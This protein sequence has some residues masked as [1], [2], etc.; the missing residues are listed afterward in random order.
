MVS[1]RHAMKNN[2]VKSIYLSFLMV[3][4]FMNAC[5]AKEPTAIV[6]DDETGKPIE[7]AVA[8]A[9]WRGPT[10]DCTL[11]QGLEGGCWGANRIIETVS[12]KEGKL[13]IWGFWNW[14]L[15]K[16][17]YPQL[18][19]YKFGY[20]C[21]DQ[22]RIFEPNMKWTKRNDFD[23]KHRIVRMKKWPVGFS[24]NE[25]ARFI[26][27]CTNGDEPKT[28]EHLL[29]KAY[30]SEDTYIIQ[31]NKKES[32]LRKQ[33]MV[34]G[35]EMGQINQLVKNQDRAHLFINYPR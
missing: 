15:G 10:S 6:I 21:W 24:F 22:K 33:P 27:N 17:R 19:V 28:K 14:H 5:Q 13:N 3:M 25:H 26:S 30:E 12:D 34:S 31:E 16:G 32:N 7:G 2:N 11:P 8:I 4:I 1:R 35:L 23:N 9:I 29:I 18:T 20:V